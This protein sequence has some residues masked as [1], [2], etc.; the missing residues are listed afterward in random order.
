MLLHLDLDKDRKAE[1]DGFPVEDGPVS[2]D[3]P[4][5][6][7]PTDP[8]KAW[9]RGQADLIG[10]FVVGEPPI[11]LERTQDLEV[12]GIEIDVGHEICRNR[13]FL[14]FPANIRPYPGRTSQGHASA[15]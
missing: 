11:V 4:V 10:Q 6:L 8:A 12:D 9:R 7:Q 13:A 1:A 3:E 5:T 14:K 2:P 15:W